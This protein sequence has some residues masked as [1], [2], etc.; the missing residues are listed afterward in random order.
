[1]INRKDR[2]YKEDIKMSVL[3]EGFKFGNITISKKY[4]L[5]K[6]EIETL[7]D[8]AGY[9][10][11]F[12]I[13]CKD[14]GNLYIFYR[15]TDGVP[16]VADYTQIN[17]SGSKPVLFPVIDPNTNEISWEIRELTSEVPD[18]VVL[19]GNPGK[20]A[21]E[22]WKELGNTGTEQDFFNSLAPDFNT[23]NADQI[24]ALK[25]RLGLDTLEASIASINESLDDIIS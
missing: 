1:M 21:Y 11:V 5:S 19:T 12:P 17:Y 15:S 9:P 25:S 24:E 20:S 23:I 8:A 10:D 4:I 6:S 18:P 3:S 7:G 13:W 16:N 14:D 22:V 2:I